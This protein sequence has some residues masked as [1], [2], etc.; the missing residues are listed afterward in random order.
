MNMFNINGDNI[1]TLDEEAFSFPLVAYKP[2]SW[3]SSAP[4]FNV[5]NN[6]SDVNHFQAANQLKH[7]IYID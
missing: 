3:A 5:N 2:Q 4:Q 6:N 1:N 7:E